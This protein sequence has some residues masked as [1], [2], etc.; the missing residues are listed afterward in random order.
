MQK[1]IDL[2]CHVRKDHSHEQSRVL[3]I[4]SVWNF[5]GNQFNF[6]HVNAMSDFWEKLELVLEKAGQFVTGY[7]ERAL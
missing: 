5:L 4:Q 3:S 7:A 1:L 2:A 6:W